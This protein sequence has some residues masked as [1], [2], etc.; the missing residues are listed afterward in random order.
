MLRR[1]FK[2]SQ[3]MKTPHSTVGFGL[4]SGIVP[5]GEDVPQLAQQG[6]P[7]KI[8]GRHF[9]KIN[10]PSHSCRSVSQP[11]GSKQFSRILRDMLFRS[12]AG[13]V[14]VRRH[15]MPIKFVPAH[16]LLKTYSVLGH[17]Y[18]VALSPEL[19]I[20]CRSVLEILTTEGASGFSD[21]CRGLPDAVFIM[22]NPGSSRPLAGA[23]IQRLEEIADRKVLVPTKP[24]TTQYQ[25]MRVMLRM[26]WNHVRVLNLSDLREPKSGAFAT[27]YKSIEQIHGF[28][29]HSLFSPS[30]KKELRAELRRKADAPLVCAWGVSSSLDSL[31]NAAAPI[32]SA[33]GVCHGLAKPGALGKY[34]H[35]LPTLQVDKEAWVNDLCKKLG[36]DAE[37]F[38]YGLPHNGKKLTDSLAL[39][40]V[41]I[42]NACETCQALPCAIDPHAQREFVRSAN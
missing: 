30:R 33:A 20:S 24:D 28:K 37:P 23:N 1:S 34:F 29:N 41:P 40:E 22:M 4:F 42:P 8:S 32:L 21:T 9:S 6:E 31:I 14:K 18:E 38:L 25:V 11:H 12:F 7:R 13:C 5:A 27:A 26:G 19:S 39:G 35:P 2:P 17:F 36:R 10:R 3:K 16:D 15:S